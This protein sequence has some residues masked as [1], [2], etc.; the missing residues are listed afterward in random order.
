MRPSQS[1]LFWLFFFFDTLFAYA[2]ATYTL[3]KDYQAGS[4]AFFDNFNFFTGAD[5]THG[6]VQ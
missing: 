2:P 4:N 5:P 3:V 1:S 6:F